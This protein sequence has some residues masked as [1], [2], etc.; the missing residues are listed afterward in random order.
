[1]SS[2]P[3]S[4]LNGFHR[5]ITEQLGIGHGDVSPEDVLDLWRAEHPL[6]AAEEENMLAVREALADMATPCFN[7]LQTKPQARAIRRRRSRRRKNWP[8]RPPLQIRPAP[9]RT[10]AA[11]FPRATSDCRTNCSHRI[12]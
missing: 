3:N 11:Q 5:F 2:A 1:M 10:S 4:E 9:R 6:R 12:Q 7:V 8:N